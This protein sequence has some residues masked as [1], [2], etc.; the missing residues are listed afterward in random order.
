M[1]MCGMVGQGFMPSFQGMVWYCLVRWGM[2]VLG[3]V[4]S[5]QVRFG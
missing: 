5:G 2:V 4:G 1:V 3:S